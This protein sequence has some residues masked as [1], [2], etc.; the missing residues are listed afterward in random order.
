MSDGHP[1]ACDRKHSGRRTGRLYCT[2]RAGRPSGPR[3]VISPQ[4]TEQL[5]SRVEL[6]LARPDEQRFRE[7][8]YRCA[9][10]IIFGIPV[11]ALQ[12]FGRS[13]GGPEAPR[14]IAI[15]QALL[16]GWVVYVAAAG[17][18]FEGLILIPRA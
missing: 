17:M 1:R 2:R 16:S 3:I 10:A 18:I 6:L 14:W 11:I 4:M 13:L 12:L 8:K 7:Y 9:Q 15:L 5:L